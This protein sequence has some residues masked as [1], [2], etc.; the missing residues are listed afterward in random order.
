MKKEKAHDSAHFYVFSTHGAVLVTAIV[1]QT[2]TVS[3]VSISAPAL[4]RI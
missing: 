2:L 3:L 4:R 1:V